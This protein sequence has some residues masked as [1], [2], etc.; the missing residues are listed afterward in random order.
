[1]RETAAQALATLLPFMSNASVVRVQS[2]L[3]QMVDQDGSPPSQGIEA[4]QGNGTG[5]NGAAK[6]NYVW[7]VRHSGLLGLKYLVAVKGDLLRGNV[8]EEKDLEME[9]DVKTKVEEDKMMADE[10]EPKVKA[11]G[12]MDVKPWVK[13]ELDEGEQSLHLLKSLVDAA[14]LGSVLVLSFAS[15]ICSA[16]YWS[17]MVRSLRDRDDDVRSAAAATLTPITDALVSLL[18]VELC[19][20][21]SILWDCLGDLKDDLSSSIGGVM[22]LLGLS[23]PRTLKSQRS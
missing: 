19:A 20:V 22:D 5:K 15:G 7:Q 18:P 13:D 2:I 6:I 9:S 10:E 3:I 17:T 1:M 4:K 23:V 8:S 14:V 12:D 11:E 16:E 21:V